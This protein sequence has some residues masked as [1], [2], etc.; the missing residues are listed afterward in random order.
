MSELS[1]T[2]WLRIRELFDLALEQPT[3]ER[4]GWVQAATEGDPVARRELL[5]LLGALDHARATLERPAAHLVAELPAD[6]D[7]SSL[8]GRRV[9]AYDVVR[10]IGYGG[11]GAVYE[12][13]RADGDF[14]KRVA[15][16]FLRAGNESELALQRFR[17][18][19]QILASLNHKNIA[20][21]LDGGVTSDGQPYFVMEYVDGV[22]ITAYCTTR[23]LGVRE[24]VRLF[25][26]VLAAVQHAHQQ[27]VV[28]RDLKPGNILVTPDG[29]VK[30]LDFGIAK[31]LR[32][33]EGPDQLPMTRGGVR[34]FTPE[35]ASPEQVRGLTLTPAS[36]IY[37]SGVVLYEL[38]TGRRPT[39]TEGRLLSEIEVAICTVPPTRPSVALVPE[40]AAASDEGSAAKWRRRIAGDLDAILLTALAKESPLRYA[41]AERFNRD[42][43]RWLEGHPVEARKAWLGYRI[44]KFIRRRPVEVA[45]SVLAIA[46]L[47]GGILSTSRQARI[48]RLEAEKAS[49][50]NQFMADMLSAA[51]PEYQGRD[52]TVRAVLD[53][54]A[55]EV[56]NR[57]LV[58][59]VEAQVRH[60]V[61]QTYYSLGLY[62]SARV[63]AD[64][65]FELRRSLH[66]LRNWETLISL[67]YV[68]AAT[69]ALGNFVKAES[70]SRV[71]VAEWRA[72]KGAEPSELANALDGLARM[73]E[74]QG[75]LD[76]ALQVKLEAV[77][78]RRTLTDSASRADLPYTLN[79]LAVSSIYNGNYAKAESLVRE[80][81]EVARTHHGPESVMYAEMLKS[82]ASMVV[83][84]GRYMEADT[85]IR[86][87][88]RLMLKQLGPKHPNYLRGMMNQAQILYQRG[89]MAGALAASSV[90]IPEI[91][92]PL[93]EADP[94]AAAALQSHGLALDALGRLAEGGVALRRSLEI[95]RKYLPPE[96]WAIASSES[97]VG[98]HLMLTGKY[99][100]AE[101]ILRAAYGEL[102]AKRGAEVAVTKRVAFRL[103]ELYG[104]WG[105]RA[106]STAWA[107]KAQ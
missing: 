47:V 72:L 55:A 6:L 33:A 98:Y 84:L 64:R 91:G 74:H 46:A 11:M 79:N 70:L 75:R 102:V 51:D 101:R 18:E 68:I 14:D 54:A 104:R 66:G 41:S 60:T 49:E 94:T 93:P 26:Q 105:R 69:E 78:I 59:A 10:L 12:G 71:N 48:A 85:A 34:L 37:S 7:E 45:A 23:R 19:R 77:A 9:G 13:V 28:H 103:S 87:A 42:L 36:D 1:P 21:L 61:A 58:P 90:V 89:D 81:L 73:I 2:R 29:T 43:Q 32:E 44:G 97:V 15:I 24:R 99:P 95:R 50:V 80:G 107:A 16:K 25:R 4:A 22:P 53:R 106:D 38:L 56:P 35:Y 17:Y 52:V 40:V 30:L 76:E 82:Y 8:V 5:S 63:H 62:D 96:H 100:E 39:P 86:Q 67:S 27:L 3:E 83:D 65:A 92:G 31:L 20:A 57:K 88:T